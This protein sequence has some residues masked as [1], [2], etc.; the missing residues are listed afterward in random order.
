MVL[1]L[2]LVSGIILAVMLERQAFQSLTVQRELDSYRFHHIARGVQEAVEAWIR[3][4][5]GSDISGALDSD[6]HAFDLEVQGSS[7][8]REVVHIYFYEAQGQV[9]ADFSGLSGDSLETARSI[10]QRLK[11][12]Q[13]SKAADFVRRE[14]PV[15]ISLLTAPPE[16]MHAVFSSVL[17]LQQTNSLIGEVQRARNEGTSLD[18]QALTGL[19]DN[20]GIDAQT[21]PKLQ[22]LI[23]V[24]PVLWQVVAES[25]VPAGAP[26]GTNPPRYGGLAIIA[27]PSAAR[28]KAASVQRTTSFVSW[29]NLSDR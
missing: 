16:V 9:L 8:Q 22:G 11:D 7:A 10:V 2:V 15:A 28:D 13:G 14:G 19:L 23:T 3:S 4:N 12:E 6:G 1:L 27:G 18:Q 24:Q 17:D 26:A 25:N 21:R 20:A 5:T 29:E